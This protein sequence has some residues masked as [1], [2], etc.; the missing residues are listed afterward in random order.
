[1]AKYHEIS[2]KEFREFAETHGFQQITLPNTNEIVFGR[3]IQPRISMRIYSSVTGDNSRDVGEDAIRV[4]LAA[5]Q[6][7]GGIKVFH[8][9]T[10][11]HRVAGWKKNLIK[12]MEETEKTPVAW[13]GCCNRIMVMR[14]KA[15]PDAV[16]FFGCSGFPEC[17]STQPYPF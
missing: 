6:P 14:K 12:R 3:I 13:C 9:A 8:S 10:R 5:R 15:A 17:R 11:V 7:D 1:M 4:V 2:E 16:P